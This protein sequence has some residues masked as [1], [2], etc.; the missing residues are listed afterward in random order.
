ML[1]CADASFFLL[2][3]RRRRSE[4]AFFLRLSVLSL[5]ISS[6]IVADSTETLPFSASENKEKAQ[7]GLQLR[8]GPKKTM[9]ISTSTTT[10]CGFWQKPKFSPLS[11]FLSFFVFFQ[12]LNAPQ[13]NDYVNDGFDAFDK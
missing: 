9:T 8:A 1:D 13:I 5:S 10:S 4:S 7:Q 11:F 3:R 12:T 2:R 6:I